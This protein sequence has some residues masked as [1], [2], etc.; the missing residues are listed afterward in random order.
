MTVKDMHDVRQ[1]LVT[2][3]N[4]YKADPDHPDYPD[5]PDYPGPPDPD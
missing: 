5:Y 3:L 4:D 1:E 2:I